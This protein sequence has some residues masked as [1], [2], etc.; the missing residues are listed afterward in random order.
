[1]HKNETG[2]D[3][4]IQNHGRFPPYP[5]KS[6]SSLQRG[7]FSMFSVV[8]FFFFEG[9]VFI[10][11]LVFQNLNQYIFSGK[12][13]FCINGIILCTNLT[14]KILFINHLIPII[15]SKCTVTLKRFKDWSKEP[16]NA[17]HYME[18]WSLQM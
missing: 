4:S 6:F 5:V 3:F 9:A 7:S 2:Q 8:F 14:H 16:V 18:K 11:L 13:Y 17:F 15:S 12:K 10:P 1:M